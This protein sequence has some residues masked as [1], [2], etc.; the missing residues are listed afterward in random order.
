V[1]DALRVHNPGARIPRP[2]G[3]LIKGY[4]DIDP[5][6]LLLSFLRLM[7]TATHDNT[8]ARTA[9]PLK[10]HSMKRFFF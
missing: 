8:R 5:N 10:I 4:Y 1:K 2:K 7:T 3:T 6:Q 9:R